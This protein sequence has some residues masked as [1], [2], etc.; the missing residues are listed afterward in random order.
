MAKLGLSGPRMVIT[1]AQDRAAGGPQMRKICLPDG[2]IATASVS[3]Q[4]FPN[5]YQQWGYLRFKSG[6]KNRRFYLGNVSAESQDESLAIGWKLARDKRVIE[7]EGLKWVAR[8]E[9]NSKKR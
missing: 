6:G 9:K 1:E 3:V 5:G 8:V 2:S 7:R 4:V